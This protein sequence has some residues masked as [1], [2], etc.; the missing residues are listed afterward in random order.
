MSSHDL[1][2]LEVPE[3]V[4]RATEKAEL[5]R[6]WLADGSQ[7]VV[8]S[9]RLWSD[10]GVWGLMLVDVARH[11]AKAYEQAGVPREIALKKIKEAMEAE[12]SSPTC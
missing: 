1:E 9:D 7:V 11:V 10:P 2:A 3:A 12:W 5:A 4:L 8:I 6:I